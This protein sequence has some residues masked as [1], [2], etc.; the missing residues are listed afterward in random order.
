MKQGI[1]FR[2]NKFSRVLKNGI[3]RNIYILNKPNSIKIEGLRE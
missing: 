1:L 3:K 2:Q